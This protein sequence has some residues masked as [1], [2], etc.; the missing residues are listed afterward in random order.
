MSSKI[1]AIANQKGGVG[2]TTTT[3]N[4]GIGL[5]RFGQHVLLIDSDPQGSLTIAL[6]Y[7]RPDTLDYTLSDI[8]D[9]IVNDKEFDPHKGL[10]HHAEG[11]DLM[12][13]NIALSGTEIS[14]MNAMSRETVLKQYIDLMREEYDYIL[15]DCMPSLGMLSMNALTAADDVIIPVQSEFLSA[16]GLEQLLLT[17]SKVRKKLNPTLEIGGILFTMV[18]QRTNMERGM[19]ELIRQ[20]VGSNFRVFQTVIPASVQAK[21]AVACGSSIYVHAPKGKVA[22]AYM[23]LT[24]EVMSNGI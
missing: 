12:P 16:K 17:C 13:A 8:M 19:S 10:F 1:I 2:K 3:A 4:L 24:K 11:V 15:I 20:S 18:N 5:A 6:G 21:E 9:S 22:Q 23:A 7:Q 14:L